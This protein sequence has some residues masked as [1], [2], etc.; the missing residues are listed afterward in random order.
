MKKKLKN[1]INKLPREKLIEYGVSC[2]EDFELLAIILRTGI[3]NKN[4]LKLSK[5]IIDRYSFSKISELNFNELIQIEGISNSKATQIIALFEIMKRTYQNKI[6]NK[7]RIVLSNSKDVYEFSKF[8]LMNKK[9]ENLMVIYVNTKNMIIDFKINEGGDNY[10]FVE[11][12]KIIQ[13]CL[14]NNTNGIFLVH[15]HPS[16]D[17]KPSEDDLQI[18]NKLKKALE[19][20]N[21]RLIDHIII[22]ESFYSFFENNNL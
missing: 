17:E 1:N 2:L 3:K 16:G 22:G 8:Y 14:N 20:F 9:F 10:V 4:V 13:E 5:E 6:S 21:I 19:L 15:N 11:P 7:K 12:K 18:T